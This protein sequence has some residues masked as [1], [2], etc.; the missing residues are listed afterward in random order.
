MFALALQ[1][2]FSSH[3]CF[4][5]LDLQ[6]LPVPMSSQEGLKESIGNK[7]FSAQVRQGEPGAP[8]LSD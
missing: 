8:V 4:L 1:Q 7:S 5:W 3:D 2:Y 6:T